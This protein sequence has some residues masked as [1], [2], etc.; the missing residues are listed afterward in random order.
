ML[1]AI[2]TGGRIGPLAATQT[3]SKV[4]DLTLS[5]DT[6]FVTDSYSIVAYEINDLQG[7]HPVA[8]VTVVGGVRSLSADGDLVAV[9]TF[10]PHLELYQLTNGTL[11]MIQ[12]ID[13]PLSPKSVRVRGSRIVVAGGDAGVLFIDVELGQPENPQPATV[14]SRLY[15]PRLSRD[16]VCQ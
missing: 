11:S 13:L 3:T 5:N 16:V 6:L 10:G 7:S 12:R 4:V 15:L 2:E 8:S 14:E 9:G 1:G